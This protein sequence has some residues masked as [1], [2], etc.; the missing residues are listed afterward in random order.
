[1]RYFLRDYRAIIM[2]RATKAYIKAIRTYANTRSLNLPRRA[3]LRLAWRVLTGEQVELQRVVPSLFG[4]DTGDPANAALLKS[5][6]IIG[7]SS[8]KS[9]RI[10]GPSS[11]PFIRVYP[12]RSVRAKLEVLQYHIHNLGGFYLSYAEKGKAGPNPLPHFFG[13]LG[14]EVAPRDIG[15]FLQLHQEAWGRVA[16]GHS[17]VRRYLK[18]I[19]RPAEAVGLVAMSNLVDLLRGPGRELYIDHTVDGYGARSAAFIKKVHR[20]LLYKIPSGNGLPRR[21]T[22]AVII[23]DEDKQRMREARALLAKGGERKREDPNFIELVKRKDDERPLPFEV[24]NTDE[25]RRYE[26][27]RL[28]QEAASGSVDRGVQRRIDRRRIEADSSAEDFNNSENL[29]I[30]AARFHINAK[31]T[32]QHAHLLDANELRACI[33]EVTRAQA[34]VDEALAQH[35]LL[36]AGIGVR[37]AIHP[38]ARQPVLKKAAA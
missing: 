4:F 13:L 14:I 16:N 11:S 8:S 25:F 32:L 28:E 33:A 35:A 17:S 38:Q 18:E 12:A 6:R 21:K 20:K 19:R 3:G 26:Q 34:L 15:N 31:R 30:E 24:L 9:F 5:F 2:F 7:L 27:Q 22:G 37:P 10:A 36:E 23:G 29:K 1:M